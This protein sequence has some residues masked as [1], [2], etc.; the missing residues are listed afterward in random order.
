MRHNGSIQRSPS[1]IVVIISNYAATQRT[2]TDH[3]ACRMPQTKKI[4]KSVRIIVRKISIT[5]SFL[6]SSVGIFRKYKS[7]TG[8]LVLR[9]KAEISEN[10]PVDACQIT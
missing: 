1:P 5:G 8:D 7:N 9:R 4:F 10:N 6:L 3:N 2:D